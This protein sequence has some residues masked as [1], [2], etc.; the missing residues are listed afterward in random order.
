MTVS[1][2]HRTRAT[3]RVIHVHLTLFKYGSA[4]RIHRSKADMAVAV[5]NQL[6][7]KGHAK[8]G[9]LYCVGS[10]HTGERA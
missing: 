4:K 6:P 3:G 7:L 1:S 5:P 10:I 8:V 2:Q 9:R